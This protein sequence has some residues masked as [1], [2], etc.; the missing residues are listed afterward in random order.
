MATPNDKQSHAQHHCPRQISQWGP[1]VQSL[2]KFILSPPD[3]STGRSL[4]T[5]AV[6]TKLLCVSVHPRQSRSA[7][8]PTPNPLL[9]NALQYTHARIHMILSALPAA[10]VRINHSKQS[11]RKPPTMKYFYVYVYVYVHIHILV[12][13]RHLF[14]T[15]AGLERLPP[16]SYLAEMHR[17][18]SQKDPKISASQC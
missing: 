14:L 1:L 6:Y 4:F 11:H 7:L 18:E 5:T 15:P 12:R 3:S 10:L 17:E 9:P 16:H 2:S 8:P 13:V